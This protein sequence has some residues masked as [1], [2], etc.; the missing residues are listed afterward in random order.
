MVTDFTSRLHSDS[1]AGQAI[2]WNYVHCWFDNQ[3][4][5][6]LV[7]PPKTLTRPRYKFNKEERIWN[8]KPNSIVNYLHCWWRSE[9]PA[10]NTISIG[11]PF[12]FL[13]YWV[14][15]KL[16]FSPSSITLTFTWRSGYFF[17]T[18][19]IKLIANLG[20]FC[21]IFFNAFSPIFGWPSKKS[22]EYFFCSASLK[23]CWHKSD[24]GVMFFSHLP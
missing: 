19:S 18:W 22:T 8:P 24:P 11:G 12:L 13:N 23:I 5:P 4:Q 1:G 17:W 10:P 9:R 20:Y 16:P 14:S 2:S 7:V 3:P 21:L 15:I 6:F